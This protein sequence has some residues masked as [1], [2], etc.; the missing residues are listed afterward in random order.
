MAYASVQSAC[1][2]PCVVSLHIPPRLIRVRR[3]AG[4][5]L[6]CQIGLHA[7]CAEYSLI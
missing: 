1:K 5:F 6:C 3:F 2:K 4:N 7:G